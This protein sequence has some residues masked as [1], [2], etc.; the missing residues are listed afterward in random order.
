MIS[1]FF[2]TLWNATAGELN[3]LRWALISIIGATVIGA[4]LTIKFGLSIEKSIGCSFVFW[5]YS[6]YRLFSIQRLINYHLVG[7]S[8]EFLVSLGDAIRRARAGAVETREQTGLFNNEFISNYL[9]VI[10][11]ICYFQT[12]FFLALALYVNYTVG[13]FAPILLICML[14]VI[15][16][17][18]NPQFFLK[19]SKTGVAIIGLV[20]FVG[21]LIYLVPQISF[22]A[23]Y[24]GAGKINLVPLSSAKIANETDKLRAQQKE[25]FNNAQLQAAYEWQKNHP[26]QELPQEYKSKVEEVGRI[27]SSKQASEK[28]VAM[29][30]SNNSSS[31]IQYDDKLEKRL[32]A[33]YGSQ[34]KER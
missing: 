13:G 22:Y 11:G 30:D 27:I 1:R 24:M 12:G 7:E 14:A 33:I 16:I 19:A 10:T 23:N 29:N 25:A 28:R 4:F 15:A 20:Y 8:F 31:S 5:V 17:I 9:F 21:L 6:G 3:Q 34:Y 32:R 18:A 2:G 26:A